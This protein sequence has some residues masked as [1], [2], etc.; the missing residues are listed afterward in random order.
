MDAV[1]GGNE[2]ARSLWLAARTLTPV[3]WCISTGNHSIASTNAPLF[4]SPMPPTDTMVPS[5]LVP[6]LCATTALSFVTADGNG[7]D[8]VRRR[9]LLEF[10]GAAKTW[11]SPPNRPRYHR[12]CSPCVTRLDRVKLVNA[13][14]VVPGVVKEE[15]PG[16]E[17]PVL[18][19]EAG[20]VE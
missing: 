3:A 15:V 7:V 9:S 10:N 4:K 1:S 12:W 13:A 6:T 2:A 14:L 11:S 5:A 20:E 18:V 19:A 8:K 16:E 17:V